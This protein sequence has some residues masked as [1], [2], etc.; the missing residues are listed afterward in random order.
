MPSEDDNKRFW[1]CP[2]IGK[3][4]E[5]DDAGKVEELVECDV[6]GGRCP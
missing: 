6:P 3:V 2:G 1:F 4:R 5:E